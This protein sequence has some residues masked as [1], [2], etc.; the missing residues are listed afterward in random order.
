MNSRQLK[1][2]SK[3]ASVGITRTGAFIGN[4]SGEIVLSFSTAQRMNHFEEKPFVTHQLFN[5][6]YIDEI[7]QTVA[8]MVD[9]AVLH[10]LVFSQPTVSRE[11]KP[12]RN[13][14]ECVEEIQ[15]R[16]YST[17]RAALLKRLSQIKNR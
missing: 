12:I 14:L 13:L 11:G 17:E 8:E 1:R 2:I 16:H 10:S 9:E 4:G 3:R 7:F 15:T 5:E 6:N